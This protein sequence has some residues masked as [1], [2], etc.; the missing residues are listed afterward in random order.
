MFII[1]FQYDQKNKTDWEAEIYK[2]L[3]FWLR[4]FFFRMLMIYW[5]ESDWDAKNSYQSQFSNKSTKMARNPIEN[6]IRE[7]FWGTWPGCR[8]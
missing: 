1:K 4:K 6:I 7:G 3:V 5:W 2:M 8:K